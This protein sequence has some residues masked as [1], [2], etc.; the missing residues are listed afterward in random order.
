MMK[1]GNT[2][3]SKEMQKTKSKKEEK[4]KKRGRGRGERK[5]RV[6]DADK[7]NIF[8]TFILDPR[9]RTALIF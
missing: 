4:K 3:R 1:E 9:R 7:R 6:F 5:S 2:Q 8:N